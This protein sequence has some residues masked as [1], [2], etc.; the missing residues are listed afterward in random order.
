MSKTNNIE[1]QQKINPEI[2]EEHS[3][4]NPCN[5]DH[6]VHRYC[7]ISAYKFVALDE[8]ELPQL[9]KDL[10]RKAVSANIK[11]TILLGKEGINFFIAGQLAAIQEYLN[12]LALNPN[13]QNIEYK[14]SY[15]DF[16]P[17]KKLR[18]KIRKEIVTFNQPGI[19][20]EQFTAPHLAPAEL[21]TWLRDHKDITLLDTRNAFEYKIG[22]FK[23]ACHLDISNFREFPAA[24]DNDS[25]IDRN[26][27]VVTFCTGGI[28][29]EKAAAY[30]LNHGFKE[31]YQ[32]D[33]GILNYFERCGRE[34]YQGECFVFDDRVTVN[35][36]LEATGMHL[37]DVRDL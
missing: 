31:V 1:S 14:F 26:K 5:I 29:C 33:G 35:S 19:E 8:S 13:F 21:L 17:F 10:K 6:G 15:S 18:V 3:L 25:Q 30:L 37:Q 16:V 11:G 24:V 34:F 4:S 9:C 28:R 32:L 22:T 2:H 12:Y 23:N 20:P 27:P 36:S 7:N